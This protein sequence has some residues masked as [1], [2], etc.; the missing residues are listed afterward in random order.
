[1]PSKSSRSPS[2]IVSSTIP[3]PSSDRE[4]SRTRQTGVVI[5]RIPFGRT[6]HHS[7]RVLFG[8][9]ALSRMRPDKAREVVDL[10]FAGGVN[11]LD[12]AAAY[13]DSELNLAPFLAEHREEVLLA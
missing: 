3:I 12:T 10:A 1:M 4:R 7:S 9:A 6:G 2:S 11:H 5:E 13:G 8:A